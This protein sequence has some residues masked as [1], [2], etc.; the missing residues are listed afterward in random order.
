MEKWFKIIICT[1]GG[2]TIM[3]SIIAIIMWLWNTI[4]PAITG[5]NCINFWQALGLSILFRLLT[6][7]LGAP[8]SH[9]KK[10]KHLHQ[11]MR[12]MSREERKDFI[13]KSLN[14]LSNEEFYNEK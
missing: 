9:R 14:K 2:I 6:G 12:N 7:H 8:I 1:T 11:M 5:W 4:I 3:V 10:H 13:C